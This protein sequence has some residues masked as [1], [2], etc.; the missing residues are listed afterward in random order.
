MA[1]YSYNE[2]AVKNLK[3]EDTSV[4]DRLVNAES[5]RKAHLEK[6]H[7]QKDKRLSLGEAI[8]EYVSDGD[9]WC[10]SSFCYVR[11]ALQAFFETIRQG[12][13]GLQAIGSPNTNQSYANFYG[14]VSAVHMS[15]TGAEMRGYDRNFD[16]QLKNGK[17]RI[18]SEWSHGSMAQ[19]FKAAQLGLP[20]VFSRQL[21]GSDMIKYNPYVK[22]MQNPMRD[23]PDPVAF[24]PA[25]F[26]DIIFIH[27]HAADKYGNARF[28]GPAVNDIAVAACA[29]KVIITAEEIVSNADIRYNNKGVSIP[30]M[31]ADAVVELPYGAA[32]GQMPGCYYWARR[33][34]EKMMRY[35]CVSDE[36]L[37]N[38][39]DYWIIDSKDQFDFIEKLGGA[40][41]LAEAKRLTKAAEYDNED[42]GV[43]FSYEEWNPGTVDGNWN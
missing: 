32:P 4:L 7:S 6:D 5:A 33:W 19:G 36:N 35:A 39:F 1:R 9:V 31:Y 29:R 40:K 24:I 28:Y 42:D 10:D 20:G 41:W 37:K 38:F 26:P 34:W 30:Y 11:S 21:L 22:V 15:Y 23:D 8:A 14:T 16:R 3:I 2:E 18:L 17:N 12:K 43:D 13:K 25:L 27:V